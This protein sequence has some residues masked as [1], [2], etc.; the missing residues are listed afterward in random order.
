MPKKKKT[1]KG[2][3]R[4]VDRSKRR[5]VPKSEALTIG[6]V[7]RGRRTPSSADDLLILLRNRRK[8]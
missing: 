8:K 3:S 6:P 4:P 1:K 2:L 5:K 7:N